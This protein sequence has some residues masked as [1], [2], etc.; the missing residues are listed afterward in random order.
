MVYTRDQPDDVDVGVSQPIVKADTNQADTSFAIDHVA[1]STVTDNGKHKKVFF[2]ANTDISGETTAGV[3]SIIC[4]A[5]SN[6]TT[7][8]PLPYFKNATG[9]GYLAPVG[10]RVRFEGRTT[11]GT[12]TLKG[13]SIN[14][15]SVDY[16]TVTTLYTV[17]MTSALS[18]AHYLPMVQIKSASDVSITSTTVFTIN[19]SG[20]TASDY[21]SVV[22]FGQIAP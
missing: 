18:D 10:A 11:T 3:Q 9:T 5:V 17:T 2:N 4:T 1:F 13:T 14:I 21:V 20:L 12:C 19:A 22:V 15:T 8:T 16:S 7:T 6:A